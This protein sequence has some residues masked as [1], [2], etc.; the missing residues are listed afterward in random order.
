MKKIFLSILLIAISVSLFAQIGATT[1]VDELS[2]A[3]ISQLMKQAE[4][5]GQTSDA[6]LEQFAMSKGI[7]QEEIAKFRAR[8]EKLK[9]QGKVTQAEGKHSVGAGREYTE[10]TGGGSIINAKKEDDA[11]I[12]P[13]IFGAGL[14]RNGSITFEPNLRI[15]TPKTYIVGPDDRLIIDLTGDN[16]RSY[17]LQVSP[18]GII[19]MEYVGRISVGGL[20]IEQAS[21][22]IK[23]VMAKTYPALKTGRTSVAI[24]LGNIRSIQVTVTGQ[25]IKAGTYTIPSLANVY[26]ALYVSGGP[27]NNGTFRNIQVIRNNKVIAV[28]DVYDFLLRGLQQGNVRLQ[29][30]DVIN[31]PAYSKRV[32][33]SGEVKEAAIFEVK[34]TETLQDVINFA[35]GFT[36]EAYTAKIKSFQNTDRERKISDVSSAQYATYQ[37]KNGDKFI[38][39]AILE[40]FENR[41]E[42]IGSVFRPGV[43]ELDKGLTLSGLIKKADGITED[44]FLNRGYINRLNPDKT[45]YFISFDV[46]KILSGE[47]KDILLTREDKVTINSLFDLREEYS[48][49]IQ[50]EVRAPGTFDFAEN[51]TLVDVVQ[52][53]GGFKEGATPN[54]IEVSRRITKADSSSRTAEL[55]IVNIDENLRIVGNEFA[56]KPFDIITIRNSESYSVQK[57]VRIEGEVKYPGM[58]TITSKDYRISDLIK[59]AGGL[60]TYAYPEGASLKRPGAEKINPGDKNAINN[61]EEEEK[62]FLNLE[63]VQDDAAVKVDEKLVQSDLVGI[64]L[65]SI[66]K[67]PLSRQDLI[68]EEGDII[69]VPKQLQTVKVTGEVLNPNSI[70]YVPGKNFKQYVNGAG[71]F[72]NSALKKRAYI[73]Y[74]NG[75]TEAAKKFLFFNN[76]PKVKP[77][78]EI[79]IPFKA[80]KEKMNTQAWVGIGTGIASLAVVIVS[81]FR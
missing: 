2:D 28:V 8:V 1:N 36:S 21:S 14:F 57:Q 34:G 33:I 72:T 62:K 71:G 48:V 26:R 38:V 60:S 18:E 42:I 69:R 32:E 16:E 64:D 81:L 39:E 30:Q 10:T 53:A 17:E 59:K 74:A 80:E 41:V 52:M 22:K 56:L 15:A 46:A 65:E 54:R 40:R 11:E 70:V 66:L 19:S 49:T 43:Y 63:R 78:A 45:Q 7:K 68:L 61:A 27:S 75:S 25:A 23:S 5:M 55:F 67:K 77:G 13:K 50:G 3:Q 29:D 47:E 73:K 76:Y 9:K 20:T 58:Y 35:K 37:P 6:Q 51:L 4:S 44:A 12:Q 24:N 79:L 31:I